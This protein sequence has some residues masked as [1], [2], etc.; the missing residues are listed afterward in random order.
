MAERG[1]SEHVLTCMEIMGGNRAARE[2][3]DAPG[4]K[5]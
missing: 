2:T 5:I 1:R 3:I 4:L